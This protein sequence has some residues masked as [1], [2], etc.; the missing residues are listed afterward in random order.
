MVSIAIVEELFQPCETPSDRLI[1]SR[2]RPAVNRNA[3]IQSILDVRSASMDLFGCSLGITN[4][5]TKLTV[6]E[7]PA[8]TKKTTFQLT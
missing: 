4:I 5:A 1:R 6:N 7:A 8:I 2:S 3:P